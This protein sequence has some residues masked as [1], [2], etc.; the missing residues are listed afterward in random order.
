[1]HRQVGPPIREPELAERAEELRRAAGRAEELAGGLTEGQLR[2]RPD[3]DS[4]SVAECLE[5]LVRT[6]EVYLR[7][8]DR[9]IDGAREDGLLG[10]GPFR[11]GFTDRWLVRL[12]EPPPGWK[13]PA[14]RI[15][16]PRE[17]SRADRASAGGVRGG[18]GPAA[19]GEPRAGGCRR[20]VALQDRLTRRLEDAD[21]L[22]LSR[23]KLRSPFVPLVRMDLGTAFAVVAA[24]QRRHLWQA[25][26]VT[27]EEGF[28]A[29]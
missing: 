28:P 27:E 20:F 3:P 26:R 25:E 29:R 14:P 7:V 22:D 23:V 24:H 9:A 1:M 21:G 18:D 17:P 11:H 16:D 13:L 2:W 10:E 8:L 12:L 15:V 5:H 4:W 19:G 6:G